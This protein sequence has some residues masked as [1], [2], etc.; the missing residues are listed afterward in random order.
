MDDVLQVKTPS[1]LHMDMLQVKTW[2]RNI[3]RIV[4]VIVAC[5]VAVSCKDIFAYVIAISGE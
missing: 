2:K 3:L 4:M 5:A 1:E